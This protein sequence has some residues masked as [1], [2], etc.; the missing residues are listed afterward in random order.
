[1]GTTS[2]CLSLGCGL[3]IGLF[4]TAC[5]TTQ[6]HRRRQYSG[7]FSEQAVSVQN[8][9]EQGKISVGM[10]PEAVY[11]ALGAPLKNGIEM[12]MPNVPENGFDRWYYRGV[13]EQSGETA[14]DEWIRFL[15]QFESVLPRADE[16][17]Y[18]VVDFLDAEV[19]KVWLLGQGSEVIR[20][21][22]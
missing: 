7:A 14:G 21:W 9:I 15:S 2:K 19:V 17:Q 22:E 10:S 4:F 13:F 3:A 18:L 16:L 8:L 6:D 1:M 20:V 12:F 11:V 5:G